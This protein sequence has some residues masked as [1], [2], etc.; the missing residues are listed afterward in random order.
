MDEGAKSMWLSTWYECAANLSWTSCWHLYHNTAV[1]R[2]RPNAINTEFNSAMESS[3]FYWYLYSALARTVTCSRWKSGV[4]ETITLY[5]HGYFSLNTKS[6]DFFSQ[7]INILYK[8]VKHRSLC[9][10]ICPRTQ[11]GVCV[12]SVCTSGQQQTPKRRV[13]FGVGDGRSPETSS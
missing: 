1:Q 11:V 7:K 5:C 9:R 12:H 6:L 10:I 4:P 13:L 8:S 2:L 3:S